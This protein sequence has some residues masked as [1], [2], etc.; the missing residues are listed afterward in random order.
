MGT[1][2]RLGLCVAALFS[3]NC[4]R[5]SPSATSD[6]GTGG[7]DARSAWVGNWTSAGTQTTTCTHGKGSVMQLTGAVTIAAGSAADTI[8]TAVNNCPLSWTVNQ[9]VATLKPGQFCTVAV[10]G[11]NVTVTWHSGS[12]SMNGN[13]I[14]FTNS[15]GTDNNCSFTQQGTLTKM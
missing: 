1:R 14:S 15:G 10:N 3:M 4:Q 9:S 8:T 12:S 11:A 13:L 7:G 5:A 6:A 2:E